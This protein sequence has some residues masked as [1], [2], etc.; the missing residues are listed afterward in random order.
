MT[1]ALGRC[2]SASS[3][4][5]HG[6]PFFSRNTC[7]GSHNDR[8]GP[9]IQW[10]GSPRQSLVAEVEPS[11]S[12]PGGHLDYWLPSRCRSPRVCDPGVDSCREMGLSGSARPVS[13]HEWVNCLEI[14]K[15]DR[16]G[17]ARNLHHHGNLSFSRRTYK[18]PHN[19]RGGH[20]NQWRG[21][22]RKPT[23]TQHI[24]NN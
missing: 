8:D 4:R 7:K 19:N 9:G 15:A 12:H 18:P 13:A 21:S 14:E 22:A 5:H 10:R 2:G 20:E 6:N 24:T 23:N 1:P 11:L 16:G 3:L 17:N